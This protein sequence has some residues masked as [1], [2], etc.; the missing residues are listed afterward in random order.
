[1]EEEGH[2]CRLCDLTHDAFRAQRAQPI[3]RALRWSGFAS[4]LL[5]GALAYF[6]PAQPVHA[7]ALT[8][9][10]GIACILVSSFL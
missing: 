9:A 7:V 2:A 3:V 8:V 4:V 1:M 5:A 6:N 10:T